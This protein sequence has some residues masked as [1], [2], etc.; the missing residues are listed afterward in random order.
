MWQT[1]DA[2]DRVFEEVLSVV[3]SVTRPDGTTEILSEIFVA[4]TPIVRAFAEF[5]SRRGE[6]EAFGVKKSRVKFAD[7]CVSC[8]DSNQAVHAYKCFQHYNMPLG[9]YEIC[10]E[11]IRD[12]DSDDSDNDSHGSPPEDHTNWVSDKHFQLFKC[13]YKQTHVRDEDINNED[14]IQTNPI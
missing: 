4:P 2:T 5:L 3:V 8:A 1:V 11:M 10:D 7:L 9:N 12:S 13:W 14:T 6:N